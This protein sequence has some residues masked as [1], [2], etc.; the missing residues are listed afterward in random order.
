MSLAKQ[1]DFTF[2]GVKYRAS[3]GADIDGFKK[4]YK[5][6]SKKDLLSGKKQNTPEKTGDISY[7]VRYNPFRRYNINK[8]FPS[9]GE[10]SNAFF[11][12]KNTDNLYRDDFAKSDLL[13]T[14]DLDG[15]FYYIDGAMGQSSTIV[16]RNTFSNKGRINNSSMRNRL[17]SGSRLSSGTGTSSNRK[18][19]LGSS[20]SKS[21]INSSTKRTRLLSGS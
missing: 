8:N 12:Q 10:Y 15:K 6:L 5:Q 4:K 19:L 16:K 9:E 13:K 3:D 18:N 17:L 20:R 1:T 21:A 11:Y 14:P 2:N 7:F